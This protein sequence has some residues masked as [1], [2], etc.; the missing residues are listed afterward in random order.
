MLPDVAMKF[1]ESS[2][3]DHAHDCAEGKLAVEFNARRTVSRSDA[4]GRV[5]I[6]TFGKS[7]VATWRIVGDTVEVTS[8]LGVG[9]V[10][11]GGLASS[12][13]IAATDK[14]RE[15]A[16]QASK[17]AAVKSDRARFNVRDA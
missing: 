16:L 13:S 9:S 12:P 1:D 14:L 6:Q 3:R 5:R 17:P 2:H 15:M 10:I 4:T 11:L 7:Y 8:T